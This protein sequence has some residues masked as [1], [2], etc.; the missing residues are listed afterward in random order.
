M[1]AGYF[2]SRAVTRP[3]PRS[4]PP[5]TTLRVGRSGGPA[6]RGAVGR[7]DRR[8]GAR[9]GC[10]GRAAAAARR[11]LERRHRGRGRAAASHCWSAVP[12]TPSSRCPT[13]RCSSPSRRARTGTHW[14]PPPSDA[15]LG[16]LECLSG[17]PGSTG[18]TPVQNVGAYGVEIADLLVDVDLYDRRTGRGPPARAR[19]RARARVPRERAQAPRR[20]GRPAGAVPAARR[21]A[22]APRSAIPSWPAR[23]ASRSG[24][25]VPAA[26]ARDGRAR[27]APRQGHGPRRRGPRH[28]ERR[29]VLH[30]PGR[31][32]RRTPRTCPACPAGP[33]TPTG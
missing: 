23:S 12:G 27:P 4:S 3:D 14:S 33:P 22:R 21:T 28:V 31:S 13:V 24:A 7:R 9:R 29:L 8:G 15:G 6:G 32:P 17:I 20:R 18:A 10:R 26:A 25:T 1:A 2:G 19:R 16:G 5:H 30:Q 11:R